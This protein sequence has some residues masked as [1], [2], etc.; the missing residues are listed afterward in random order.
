MANATPPS[1]GEADRPRWLPWAV[2]PFQSRFADIEGKRIHYIDEGSGPALLLVSA[3]QWSFMFRDVI[4]R[5]RGQ[6]RCLTLD[7]P[8]CGL[9]PDAPGHDHSI[10]ANAGVLEGFI[11]AVDLQ[12]I[13]MIVHDVGGPLGFMAAAS[14]P[15]RFRALVI[16]NTFGWPL[17]GYPAVR[18]TLQV[19]ASPAFGAVNSL[20]N[21]LALITASRYGV[22]RHMS[23]ADRQAFLRPWR[24][25]SNRRATQQILAG[26]LRIDPKLIEVERSLQTAMAGLPVLTLFGR[27]ND[28]YGWQDRFQ[29]VF[30]HASA[31]GIPDGHHF[32]FSDDAD[33]YAAAVS[34]WWAQRAAA[35]TDTS[36]SS[37]RE[38][39][40]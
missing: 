27:K 29:Q 32:P 18:R 26:V 28:P 12:D 37:F 6:F 16:S 36:T 17:A 13:T 21:A 10:R 24:K 11:D 30:P 7:F 22:G 1:T 38:S 4:M 31:A 15:E 23:R 5:L 35:S 8:G 25:R 3:G 34:S 19:V 2:F 39:I 9:S 40:R 14:R 33:S 20:T